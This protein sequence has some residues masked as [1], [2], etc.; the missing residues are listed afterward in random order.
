MI[1]DDDTDDENRAAIY[2]AAIRDRLPALVAMGVDTIAESMADMMSPHERDDDDA[3]SSNPISVLAFLLWRASRQTFHRG[4]GG[5][6][7]PLPF[8]PRQVWRAPHCGGA[9]N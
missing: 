5:I 2:R 4:N 7:I 1:D 9:P 8:P 6:P 3:A